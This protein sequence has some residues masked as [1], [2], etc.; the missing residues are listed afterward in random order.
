M[1]VAYKKGLVE[2]ATQL[3]VTCALLLEKMIFF[4]LEKCAI[5]LEKMCPYL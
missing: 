2:E 1:H 5:F 3:L 4:F